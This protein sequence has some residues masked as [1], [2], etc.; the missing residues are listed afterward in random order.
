MEAESINRMLGIPDHAYLNDYSIPGSPIWDKTSA[1]IGKERYFI[2]DKLNRGLTDELNARVNTTLH[3]IEV[4]KHEILLEIKDNHAPPM[5]NLYKKTYSNVHQFELELKEFAIINNVELNDIETNTEITEFYLRVDDGLGIPSPIL[6]ADLSNTA[7]RIRD[8]FQ[9]QKLFP[10]ELDTPVFALKTYL[11]QKIGR[12]DEF[13]T[14]IKK[15]TMEYGKSEGYS[16][17]NFFQWHSRIKNSNGKGYNDYKITENHEETLKD[18]LLKIG[19]SEAFQKLIM[20][21]KNAWKESN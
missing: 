4:L 18:Y 7:V 12:V 16:G 2:H 8:E 3:E 21:L 19:E 20:Y 17:H 11:F 1:F 13:K 15:S 14:P 5:V 10:R 9:K 6:K